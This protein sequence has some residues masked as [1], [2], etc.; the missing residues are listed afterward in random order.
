MRVRFNAR[1]ETVMNQTLREMK[2]WRKNTKAQQYGVVRMSMSWNLMNERL[3]AFVMCCNT[4]GI[5]HLTEVASNIACTTCNKVETWSWWHLPAAMSARKRHFPHNIS[6]M[7]GRVT[8]HCAAMNPAR[9]NGLLCLQIKAING[10]LEC[11]GLFRHFSHRSP[12]PVKSFSIF[13][14]METE[15]ARSVLWVFSPYC[16][17]D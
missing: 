16:W 17:G 3:C 1:L 15:V 6:W 11:A 12:F 7:P 10:T 13:F 5:T 2:L 4:S 8:A 14:E 9:R